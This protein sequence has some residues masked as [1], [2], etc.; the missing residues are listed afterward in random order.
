MCRNHF[1]MI[2][3]FP[4]YSYITQLSVL[5]LNYLHTIQ[6]HHHFYHR[7]SRT[8]GSCCIGYKVYLRT[9][10]TLSFSIPLWYH[11]I[12]ICRMYVPYMTCA[13]N[14]VIHTLN[15]VKWHQEHVFTCCCMAELSEMV[16]IPIVLIDL[17]ILWA[18]PRSVSLMKSYS[19]VITRHY[20]LV[21]P[22][23]LF[24]WLYICKWESYRCYCKYLYHRYNI[25][26]DLQSPWCF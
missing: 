14:K 10:Y 9:R 13:L 24:I 19:A 7:A 12:C 17:M 3:K 1:P 20:D 23:S 6:N 8:S 26:M 4:F 18:M 5:P 16:A 22:I 11:T 21:V 15:M 25:K 2:L